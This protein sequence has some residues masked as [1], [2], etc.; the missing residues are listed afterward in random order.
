ML[1]HKVIP[2]PKAPNIITALKISWASTSLK[3]GLWTSR[4]I[5]KLASE[6]QFQLILTWQ[7]NYLVKCIGVYILTTTFSWI[8]SGNIQILTRP[9]SSF[10]FGSLTAS[11]L[12]YIPCK[13][14]CGSPSPGRLWLEKG[15]CGHGGLSAFSTGTVAFPCQI[16]SLSIG[17]IERITSSNKSIKGFIHHKLTW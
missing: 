11:F 17:S 13:G 4:A 10:F 3:C 7:G 5:A 2:M 12:D 16:Q 1:K 6:L 14:H 15:F 8:D 9:L